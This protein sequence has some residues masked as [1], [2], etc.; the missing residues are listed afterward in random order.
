[1]KINL[2]AVVFGFVAILIFA[3]FLSTFLFN[4]KQP[5]AKNIT[6]SNLTNHGPAPNIQGIAHWINSQPLSLSQLRGKV[7]LIDFWTYS[8]INC[9]RTIPYLNAWENKYGNNGLIIIGVHTPEF[10]FETNYSNVLN[11]VHGFGIGYAVAMDSNDSTWN[12]YNNHYWPADYII[13][14]NGN[15]R[16][17]Q[18]GEGDYNVTERAIQILLEDAGYKFTPGFVNLTSTVDFSGIGTPEIYLGYATARAPIGNAQSFSPNNITN[19]TQVNITKA[20]TPYFYGKWYNAPDSI[21]S[22]NNSKIFLIY[23]AKNVNIVASGNN[24]LIAVKL[25]GKNLSSS[26]LG[27][28]TRMYNDLAIANIGASKLYNVVSGPSYGRHLLEIDAKP[29]LRLYTFTFG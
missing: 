28:D 1:M 12:A 16:Y 19:Y 21:I 6:L 26:Y 4:H 3:A 7:V 14:K 10:Q 2:Y 18:P 24:T 29:G 25:D 22:L 20:N 9:I 23:I 8:C 11:A 15:I 13:D 27:S 17:Y 5:S